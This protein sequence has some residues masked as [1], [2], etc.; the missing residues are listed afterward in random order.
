[1]AENEN[2]QEKTQEPT[3]KKRKESRDKGQVPR[4]REVSAAAGLFVS[5]LALILS[6]D[7]MFAGLYDMFL[8]CYGQM[9]FGDA[10]FSH[11]ANIGGHVMLQTAWILSI[12]LGVVFVGGVVVNGIQGRGAIK[13]KW[14]IEW[15]RLDPLAGF[16]KMFLSSTPLVELAKGVGK[17]G[18]IGWLVWVGAEE[19][20]ADLPSLMSRDP[21][22]ILMALQDMAM[23]VLTRALPVAVIL[24][25]LDYVYQWYQNHEQM[26]MTQQE[27]KEE[28]KANEGDPK[29]KQARRNRARQI[30]MAQMAHST[31]KADVVITNPTHFAVAL[32]YRKEEAMAPMVVAKGVDAVAQKIKLEA[33]R[34]DIPTIEN[35]TL[36]RALYATTKVGQMIPES[37]YGAVARILAVIWKRRKRRT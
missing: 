25:V 27:V 12:P 3:E 4:S 1:M 37:M 29:M 22:G 18:I 32:R 33:R 19:A 30:S 24:A 21:A 26:M 36:A 10:T 14:E 20:V 9:Y 35:R 8:Y 15:K 11:M 31:A 13:T 6:T 2:G 28:H 16:K 5:A 34:R 23:I 17:L 7:H